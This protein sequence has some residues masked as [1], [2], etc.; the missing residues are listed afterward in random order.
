MASSIYITLLTLLTWLLNNTQRT[1]AQSCWRETPC[2]NITQPVYPGEWDANN[3]APDS[4]NVAPVAVYSLQSGREIATWPAAIPISSN[5]SGVYL[6]FGKEVGGVITIKFSVY[7]VTKR[8]SREQGSLGLAFSEAKNWVGYTSDSS[9]GNYARPDDAIYGTFSRTGNFTYVMPI[10]YLRGGFRYLTLFLLGDGT[11]IMI[12][13]V[14]LEL[15][16][17]P[18]WSNLRAYQGY[19]HSND[20][21]LNKIWYSGAYTLQLNAISPSTGRTWPPPRVAWQNDA[22][23]GPGNTI[24]VDGAKRDRTVWPGDMGVAGPASFY[25]TGDLESIRNSLQSLYDGQAGSGLLP[26]SGKPL[27]ASGSATYHMWTMIGL[28]NYAIFSGD[29]EFVKIQWERYVFAMTF[30]LAQI[31][32]VV[33]LVDISFYPNDWGR[34][35][36]YGYLAS[37]QMLA[38][39]TLTTGALLAEWVGDTT[40]L[41][42]VWLHIAAELKETINKKLWDT[43]V[44][45]FKDNYGPYDTGLYPQDGNSLAIL[46]GVVKGAGKQG[47]SI[48]SWLTTNWRAIGPESPELPGEVSPFVTSFEIQAH[49]LARQPQRALDLI[50][51]SWG[52]YLNNENGTQSTMIEGYLIDGTF[53]YRHD[54]GYEEVYSY[55]SHA[56]GWSTGPIT[57]LTEHTLGLSVTGL[58]GQTIRFAPQLG[59]LK[60]VQG[61]FVTNF[62]KCHARLRLNETTGCTLAELEVPKEA[63]TEVI[64]LPGKCRPGPSSSI[65]LNGKYVEMGKLDILDGSGDA[66]LYSMTLPG[67]KHV[68]EY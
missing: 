12:H 59:D 32:P 55:T 7:S 45:A 57:A 63:T 34:F 1:L 19:F 31:D 44:G 43:D 14:T 54:A 22:T 30:I 6:D 50:R 47:R 17:Q 39:H 38:Y 58:G 37:A 2:S 29:V 61:G 62:G 23:L 66:K 51:T 53:G 10:E 42:R 11:S 20:N 21:L 5:T 25:S 60:D 9:N 24:N 28:Y 27:N 26:F 18:T 33:G 41:N 48:S 40:G 67:G 36:S 68:F 35:K 3:F 52:W 56:H 49:F 8:H 65:Q 16:F 4:R 13:N 46:L 64:L 15:S